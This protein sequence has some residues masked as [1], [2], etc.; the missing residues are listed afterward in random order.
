MACEYCSGEKVLYQYTHYMK[1]YISSFG[2]AR[3]IEIECDLCPPHAECCMKSIP[4]RSTFVINYC[5][6]CGDC[7]DREVKKDESTDN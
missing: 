5:P 6:N 2:K 1:L 7:L 3:T 4:A